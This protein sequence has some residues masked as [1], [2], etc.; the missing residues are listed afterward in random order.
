M[1]KKGGGEGGNLEWHAL[2]H[3]ILNNKFF[4]IILKSL[5]MWESTARSFNSGSVS[6]AKWSKHF[7]IYKKNFLN[8]QWS[9]LQIPPVAR[10]KTTQSLRNVKRLMQIL[11]I[12]PIQAPVQSSDT[13]VN[14]KQFN[15]CHSLTR[16]FQKSALLCIHNKAFKTTRRA[17]TCF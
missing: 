16:D 9:S 11:K 15:R 10:P 13:P 7:F 12:F 8:K 4:E 17:Q 3:A 14:T 1:A 2:T 5:Y 6:Q